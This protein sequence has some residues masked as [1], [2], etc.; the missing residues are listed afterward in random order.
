MK[1]LLV[2]GTYFPPQ[3]GGISHF[4]AEIATALGP[5]QVCCLTG[6]PA[7]R[8]KRAT[9]SGPRVYRRPAVFSKRTAVQLAGLG[10][11]MTEIALRE[12]PRVV[13]FA[14]ASEAYL[15]PWIER[16][17]G[18]PYVVYAHGNEILDAIQSTWDRPRR[19]L[20]A[21]AR[22]FAN[23]RFTAGLVEEAGVR[24]DRIDIIHPGCDTDLFRPVATDPDLKR[25]LLGDRAPGRVILSVG[26]LV[27]RKGHD[28]VLRCMPELLRR[29]PDVTYLIV[30][31][32]RRNYENLDSL[33]RELGVRDQLR[34]CFDLPTSELPSVYAISDVFAMPS[35]G[36]LELCDVEGFGIVF[37]EANACGK[38]VVGGRSGGIADAIADG[39][40][41]LLV[42]PNDPSDTAR[43]ISQLLDNPEAAT[44]MGRQGRSRVIE[45]FTWRRV[46]HRVQA[47]L[48]GT[49]KEKLRP[50]QP[51]SH[52]S[53]MS[54]GPRSLK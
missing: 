51:A 42:D 48:V 1:S 45:Q 47:A 2:S 10:A 22:V 38:P 8:A 23:S 28:T 3:V 54:S 21:A 35:R 29:F 5:E 52:N 53:L 17:L 33:A 41:G 32:D 25:R 24:P 4:M 34:V 46:A 19:A 30:S 36:R 11:A 15:G 14:M 44:R 20:Q 9:A 49:R 37:L 40:S 27:P 43:A 13:Q 39:V 12:R 6:V 18:L 26:G 31:S 7:A 50:G 16:A